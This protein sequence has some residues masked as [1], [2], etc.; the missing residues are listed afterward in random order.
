MEEMI[1]P[2]LGKSDT[3]K[4]KSSQ[5][6]VN[7]ESKSGMSYPGSIAAQIGTGEH[8][9]DSF[10]WMILKYCFYLGAIFSGGMMLAYFHYVFDRNEPDKIDI[11]AALK[12]VWSIFTPILTLALG[13]A[14]GKR[15]QKP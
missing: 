12:D 1:K 6:S 7:S 3:D 10:I 5:P 4:P 11:I 9:K 13:Y 8:A 2:S 14:F 15:E